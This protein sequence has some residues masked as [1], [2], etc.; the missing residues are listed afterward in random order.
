M[1]KIRHILSLLTLVLLAV[2]GGIANARDYK[3][4]SP[5][6]Q[7]AVTVSVGDSLTWTVSR[8]SEQL[9]KPSA[10]WMDI[11][12]LSGKALTSTFRVVS[13]RSR[14][15]DELLDVAVPTKFSTIRDYFNE[16][17]LRSVAVGAS[18]SALTTMV[19][20]TGSKRSSRRTQCM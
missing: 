15:V 19:W 2:T 4:T 9:L 6:G 1:M 8:A 16:L 12:D 3:L 18:L 14:I 7:V 5:D 17:R 10:I 13:A 11:S 20:P